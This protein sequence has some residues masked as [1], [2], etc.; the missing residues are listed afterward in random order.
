MYQWNYAHENNNDDGEHHSHVRQKFT[1]D[2]FMFTRPNS[3]EG[4][5]DAI[6]TSRPFEI[7]TRTFNFYTCID[8]CYSNYNTR[9]K[10]NIFQLYTIVIKLNL[11]E[12][13]Y[14]TH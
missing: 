3:N 10:N 4:Q 7:Y 13:F 12:L 6:Q 11:S 1:V 9:G 5:H 2:I 14:K 8:T